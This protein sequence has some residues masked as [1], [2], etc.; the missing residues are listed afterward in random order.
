MIWILILELIFLYFLSRSLSQSLFGLFLVI[1]RSRPVAISIILLLQF[2]GTVIHELAHLFTAEILRVPT[3]KL[4]LVPENIRESHIRSGSV[5]IAESDPFRRY[6]IGLA[7]LIAGMFV[8]TAIAYLASQG[9][10]LQGWVRILTGYILFTVSNTMFSSPE[11]LKGFWP[12]AF[13]LGL[14]ILGGYLLG[15]RFGLTGQTLIIATDILATLTRSL[16]LV[17]AINFVL[18]G[19]SW[20]FTL[21]LSKLFR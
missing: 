10:T 19:A 9:E 18:L 16:G 1:F 12:F 15:I 13:V 20:G 17:I 3:G 5:A 4:T 7:P 14:F 21:I 2:P 8:L 11:D 6:A